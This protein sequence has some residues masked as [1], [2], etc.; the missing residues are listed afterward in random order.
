MSDDLWADE[1]NEAK[2]ATYLSKLAKDSSDLTPID[3]W[4]KERANVLAAMQSIELSESSN[5]YQELW[6]ELDWQRDILMIM[7]HD[8]K[9]TP[10]TPEPQHW[11]AF[12]RRT[13]A[14]LNHLT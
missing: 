12:R 6:E 10:R 11:G 14:L 9:P 13:L 1:K 4:R 8:H 7:T 5:E 3:A 2:A